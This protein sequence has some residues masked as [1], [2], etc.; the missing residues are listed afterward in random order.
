MEDYIKLK[1]TERKRSKY[2]IVIKKMG[3]GEGFAS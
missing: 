2:K 3:P 1:Q